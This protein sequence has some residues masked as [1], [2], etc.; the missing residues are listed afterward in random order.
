[1]VWCHQ[2]YHQNR[3]Q[4]PDDARIPHL[5][6]TQK[7]SVTLTVIFGNYCEQNLYREQINSLFFAVFACVIPLQSNSAHNANFAC[8]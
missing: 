7:F 3:G 2:A 5:Y 1:M 6:K 8:D 4:M